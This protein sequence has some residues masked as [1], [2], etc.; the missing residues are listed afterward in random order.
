MVTP[1]PHAFDFTE[2]PLEPP[3][4][5]ADPLMW[6]L[7]WRLVSDHGLAADGFCVICRPHELHPCP[8]RRIGIIGLRVAARQEPNRAARYRWR[9]T[10]PLSPNPPRW[11]DG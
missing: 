7:A 3:T 8:P 9:G 5:T 6:R 11:R 1:G 10:A 4:G 2:P